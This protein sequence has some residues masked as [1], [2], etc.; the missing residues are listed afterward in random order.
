MLIASAQD[1]SQPQGQ[2]P[3]Q[4]WFYNIIVGAHPQPVEFIFIFSA[5][6][7]EQDRKIRDPAYLFE[8]CISVSIRYVSKEVVNKN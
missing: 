1:G 3:G 5:R 6:G 8:E 2:F 7:Q 4:K